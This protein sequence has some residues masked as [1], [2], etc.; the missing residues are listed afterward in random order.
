M[1]GLA[2]LERRGDNPGRGD[3]WNK[4]EKWHGLSQKPSK[5]YKGD[6]KM[7]VRDEA[8]ELEE[9]SVWSIKEAGHLQRESR[10]I[11]VF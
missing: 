8:K 6:G 9:S 2:F 3:S 7:V 4:D 5:V 11:Q 1:V 10:S